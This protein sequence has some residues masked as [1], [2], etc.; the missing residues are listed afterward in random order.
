M[1][2]PKLPDNEAERLRTLR[3]L[4]ILD[5]KPEERFDNITLLT[6]RVFKVPIALVSIVDESRQW[7][8]SCIGLP[9]SETG[10]DISFCG[11]TILNDTAFVIPD[12]LKDSRFSDNP[13]VL[14]DP[15][16]R[17]Y[18]G[19]PI[20]APNGSKLG[21]LCIIDREPREFSDTDI[22][23]LG[24]FAALVEREISVSYLASIDELT[25]ISNRRGF[26]T[27]A[28]H[29][30]NRCKRDNSPA[31][32]IFF[33]LNKF[34]EINDTFGHAEGD[35]AL[36]EFVTTIKNV[37]RDSDIF[38]RI[39]GDEFVL[40]LSNTTELQA[41]DVLTRCQNLLDNYNLKMDRDYTISFSHGMVNLNPIQH[42]SI[43]NILLE[44]D[45]LM[46]Q[47]KESQQ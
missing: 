23:V 27:L 9:V 46:Y 34:K 18:A 25:G 32:L 11:H 24:D 38:G 42:D 7:F 13:L 37:L 33:D 47:N 45:S 19:Y 28:Q 2:E 12:T 35:K 43:E 22:T 21:T 4:N 10:R 40:L 5:T 20:K 39:G 17:F 29:E 8:K 41:K 36:I 44:A 1:Q 6:Q 15:K 31:S 14:S 30:L 3:S 16:I 26:M